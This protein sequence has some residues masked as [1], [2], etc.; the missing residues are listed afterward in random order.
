M[1][2]C[3]RISQRKHEMKNSPWLHICE[4]WSYRNCSSSVKFLA[5]Q[6]KRTSRNFYCVQL[7]YIKRVNF[8]GKEFS[9]LDPQKGEK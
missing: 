8:V 6:L 9:T 1:L 7:R 2:K 5:G 4:N 3:Y